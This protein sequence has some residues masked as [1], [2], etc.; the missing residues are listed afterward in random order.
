MKYNI[1]LTLAE[2]GDFSK[3]FE[4]LAELKQQNPFFADFWPLQVLMTYQLL[5]YDAACKEIQEAIKRC[6]DLL[7]FE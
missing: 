1:A 6:G 5:G 2:C 4:E 7:Q 3:A